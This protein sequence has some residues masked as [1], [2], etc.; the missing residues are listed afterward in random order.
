MNEEIEKIR[1]KYGLATEKEVQEYLDSLILNPPIWQ[2]L[3][4]TFMAPQLLLL[5]SIYAFLVWSKDCLKNKVLF[6]R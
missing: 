3:L 6:L 4:A 5:I 2:K 1:Q